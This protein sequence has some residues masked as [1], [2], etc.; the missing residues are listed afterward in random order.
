MNTTAAAK[1]TYRVTFADGTTKTFASKLPI[2]FALV[3]SRNTIWAKSATRQ[4]VEAA[5]VRDAKHLEL[6]GT[7][8]T[9]VPVEVV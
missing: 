6:T 5:A 3:T 2:A 9:V 4:G 7:T 1:T 8:T